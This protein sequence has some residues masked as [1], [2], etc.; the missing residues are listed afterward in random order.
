MTPAEFITRAKGGDWRGH[1]GLIPGPGHSA[2]DRSMSVTNRGLDDVLLYSFAGDDELAFKDRLRA[3]G[4][5]PARDGNSAPYTAPRPRLTAPVRDTREH[6]RRALDLWHQ[7]RDPH[8]TPVETYLANRGVRLP[9]VAADALRWH[10]ACPFRPKSHHGCMVALLRH[11]VTDEP[12]GIHRTAIGPDG[13]KAFGKDSKMMLGPA[14]GAAIK[15]GYEVTSRVGVAEGIE[16][17]LSV[18]QLGWTGPVWAAAS[19]NGIRT[20]PLLPYCAVTVFADPGHEGETAALELATRWAASGNPAEIQTPP[21]DLDFND[22]LC[23]VA[24]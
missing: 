19:A 5:L 11:V 22:I 4:L 8:G 10:P 12:Q 21:G 2:A 23:G 14:T 20:M 15:L 9:V 3:E 6:T 16:T 1:G 17:A 24:S 18:M 13:H 7:A